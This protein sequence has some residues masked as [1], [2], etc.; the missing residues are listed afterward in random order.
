MYTVYDMARYRRIL[1]SDKK[2][3]YDVALR[4]MLTQIERKYGKV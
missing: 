4:L 3:L 1:P 2:S